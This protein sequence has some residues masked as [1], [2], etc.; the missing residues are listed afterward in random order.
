MVQIVENWCEVTGAVLG[1][2]AG[3]RAE[4]RIL[5]LRLD[6]IRPVS[7]FPTLLEA[8]AGSELRIHMRRE[9]LLPAVRPGATVTIRVRRAGVSGLWAHPD[10]RPPG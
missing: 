10:W 8:S 9:Q 2:E 4:H 7:G 5:R 1:I 3:P 6:H